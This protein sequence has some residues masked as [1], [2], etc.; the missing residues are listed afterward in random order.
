[1][2]LAEDSE[3]VQKVATGMLKRLGIEVDLVT[4]GRQAV[5]AASEGRHDLILMDIHMP[6]VN[7]LDATRQIRAALPKH[8][9]PWIV[10][11]TASATREDRE[12]CL[13]AG[14][15]DY[16]TKPFRVQVLRDVFERCRG[17]RPGSS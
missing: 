1:M 7:G 3:V 5:H 4:N 8:T 11:M 2:L 15:D 12:R 10:A 9:Q 14:M 17:P 13:E 16:I 6:E